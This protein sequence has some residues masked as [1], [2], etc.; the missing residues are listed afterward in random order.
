[1]P[2][3]NGPE[4]TASAHTPAAAPPSVLTISWL[5]FAGR[6]A[7]W[8]GAGVAGTGP[9]VGQVS[10]AFAGKLVPK[11]VTPKIDKAVPNPKR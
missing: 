5:G 6:G 7:T 2:T 9:G 1:M 8:F 3:K 4:V 10:F 11:I